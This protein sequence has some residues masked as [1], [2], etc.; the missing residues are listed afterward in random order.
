MK[1]NASR[2]VHNTAKEN[3]LILL[4]AAMGSRGSSGAIEEQEAAGQSS[5]VNSTQLPIKINGHDKE[6]MELLAEWGVKLGEPTDNLFREATLPEG[7]KEVATDHSMWS[8]VVD[9]EGNERIS[10]FYKASFYDRRAFMS[11]CKHTK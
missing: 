7:W 2:N 3:P 11:V 1:D 5:F 9:T 4:A 10:I 6:A 8:K